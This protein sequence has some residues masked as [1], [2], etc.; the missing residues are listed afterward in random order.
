MTRDN[1]SFPLKFVSTAIKCQNPSSPYQL[2]SF[3]IIPANKAQ[4][5]F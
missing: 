5:Q 1:H 3:Q 2:F 4:V